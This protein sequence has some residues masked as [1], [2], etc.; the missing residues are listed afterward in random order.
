MHNGLPEIINDS[1]VLGRTSEYPASPSWG[2][3]PFQ[4]FMGAMAEY[5]DSIF[6][7]K[8]EMGMGMG[9][10]EWAW[11]GMQ[12]TSRCREEKFDPFESER[13]REW[14]AGGAYGE[15]AFRRSVFGLGTA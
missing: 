7:P 6:S 8:N 10:Y 9:G 12:A 1:P 15:G 13:K 14:S 11:S 4:T 3:Q 5:E 2:P